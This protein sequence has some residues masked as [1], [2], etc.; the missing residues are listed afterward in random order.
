MWGLFIGVTI[1]VLQ[2]LAVYKLGMM[3]FKGKSWERLAGGLLFLVK[4]AAI[5]FILYLM[6]TISLEHVIWTAGG[7]LLG[8]SAASVFYFKKLGKAK[9]A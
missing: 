7:M 6:S 9:K 3:I 2:L 1:G 4:M 5:V 8:L